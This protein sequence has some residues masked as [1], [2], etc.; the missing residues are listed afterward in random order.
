LAVVSCVPGCPRVDVFACGD[1]IGRCDLR[2]GGTCVDGW[3]AYP[4]SVC[5][6]GLRW[7]ADAPGVGGSC[8]PIEPETTTIA[9]PTSHSDGGSGSGSGSDSASSGDPPTCGEQLVV[10]VD[11]V[12]LSGEQVLEGYP[13]LVSLTDSALLGI[14][15][16]W[17]SDAD[18]VTLPFELE[19]LEGSTGTLRAWV[20]LPTWTPGE[21]L[22]LVLRFGDP[23]HASPADA[24]AVWPAGF[25]G[26]WHLDEPLTG[27][28]DDRQL[29]STAHA[30]HGRPVG[31]MTPDHVVDA[32]IGPGIAFG[33]DDDD[34]VQFVDAAFAG[35]LD[36]CTISIWARVDADGSVENPF[37]EK[38]NGD[39]LYPRCRTRP[40]E[41]GA[42]QCQTKVA[43]MPLAVRAPAKLVPRGQWHHVAITFDAATGRF[44]L[45]ANGEL[46][47]EGLQ[48]A[49]PHD[50]G[51]AIPQIGR[52]NEFGGLLGVL[53][54]F[55]VVDHPLSG[56]WIAADERSQRD[57]AAITS[58]VGSPQP[59]PC[60]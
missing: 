55:R 57:P 50:A 1:G 39:S 26:V 52:I 23:E 60:P 58:V 31:G 8:V 59:A 15:D 49:Q 10:R 30:E 38:V 43:G 54:E 2:E 33:G 17:W 27:G 41:D 28:D 6:S 53:D 25:L 32:M 3:C 42:L 29:D 24:A 34:A 37:F 45:Y 4:D 20:R 56:A 18:G 51:D 48:A 21:P 12:A 35:T 22:D 13:L 40:D 7:R 16:P 46:V 36:S 19:A 14:S 9:S 5:D 44:E 47:D 11:T